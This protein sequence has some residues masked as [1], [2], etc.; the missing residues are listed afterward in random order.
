MGIFEGNTEITEVPDQEIDY[1]LWCAYESLDAIQVFDNTMMN[2]T[3]ECPR[4]FYWSILRGF[5]PRRKSAALSFG[6]A[7]HDFLEHYL[8]DGDFADA[9]NSAIIMFNAEGVSD[10][11]RNI[12]TLATFATMYDK[13]FS[14]LEWN[15][16]GTEVYGTVPIADFMYGAKIDAVADTGNGQIKGIEHKTASMMK[17]RFFDMFRMSSQCRGYFHVLRQQMEGVQGLILNV[18]H[19]VK[20]PDFYRED[21]RWNETQMKEWLDLTIYT[22]SDMLRYAKQDFW[23]QCPSSCFSM[24]GACPYLDLCMDPKPYHK[25]VPLHADYQPRKWEPFADFLEGEK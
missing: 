10:Q 22:R 11:K 5:E 15:I 2:T 19:I 1:A 14:H 13:Q 12:T 4:K 16:L 18:A 25:V 20:E 7:W 24:Y 9:L 6:S 23:P 17:A 3:R 8:K 21:L